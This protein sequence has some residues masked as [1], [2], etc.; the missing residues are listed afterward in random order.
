MI[1]ELREMLAHWWAV[2]DRQIWLNEAVVL[3]AGLEKEM[4]QIRL[5]AM[6]ARDSGSKALMVEALHRIETRIPAILGAVDQN[7]RRA[8]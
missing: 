8:A 3:V 4:Q 1:K 6:T 7:K 2:D 5:D